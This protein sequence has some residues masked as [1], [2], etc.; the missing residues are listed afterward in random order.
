M[1]YNSQRPLS[2]ET[3]FHF[4][5]LIAFPLCHCQKSGSSR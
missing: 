1:S 4:P 3:S 5:F 2:S